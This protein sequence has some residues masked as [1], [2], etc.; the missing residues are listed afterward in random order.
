MI[1]LKVK[2]RTS[3]QR[4]APH[5]V[6][7]AALFHPAVKIG[8]QCGDFIAGKHPFDNQITLLMKLLD[9]PLRDHS[10]SSSSTND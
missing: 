6:V 9:L 5:R 4:L 3:V 10:G 7:G 1:L 2:A 8:L